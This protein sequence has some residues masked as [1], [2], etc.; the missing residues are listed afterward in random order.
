[1]KLS[2]SK[3]YKDLTLDELAHLAKR[4][5]LPEPLVLNAAKEIVQLP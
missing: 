1:L 4:A 5:N 3:H 2:R